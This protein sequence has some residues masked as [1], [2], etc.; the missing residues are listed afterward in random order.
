MPIAIVII[1]IV[2]V[3]I[4]SSYTVQIDIVTISRV[5]IGNK[6]NSTSNIIVPSVIVTKL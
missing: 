2:S 6:C 4:V 5:P 3:I 1:F